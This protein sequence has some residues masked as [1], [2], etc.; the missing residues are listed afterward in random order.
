MLRVV[1]T[2]T[3]AGDE[4]P[5]V[6]RQRFKTND[7]T[8]RRNGRRYRTPNPDKPEPKGISRKAAKD[9]KEIFKF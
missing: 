2:A 3:P 5:I 8:S 4:A 6:Y 7:A 9:A 1:S